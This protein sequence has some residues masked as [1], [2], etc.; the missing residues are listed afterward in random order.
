VPAQRQAPSTLG[1]LLLIGL[2]AVS[3]GTTGSVTTILVARAE[4]SPLLIGAVRMWVAAIC[5]VAGTCLAG[6]RVSLARGDWRRAI[7]LGGCMAAYQV[8]YFTAVT[9]AGI[10]VAAVVAICSAPLLIAGLAAATLREPLSR[11][12]LLALG[13][14]V[15]GTALLIATPRGALDLSERGVA[16]ALLALAAGLAYALYVVITKRALAG[17]APLPLASATFAAAAILLAPVFAWVEAPVR[18]IVLGWP[19]LLYLGAVATAGAY[20]IYTVGLR[21]V[22]ASVAGI[23]TLL[24]PLTATVLGTLVF[25]E[26]LGSLGVLGAALLLT[27]LVLV[28]T[29]RPS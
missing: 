21:R 14:G 1:G 16:G 24:E 18:Q 8:T 22:P 23:A 5:L 26:R 7:A 10:T 11:R 3:W 19:W 15:V 28:L 2:A 9:L 4:A 27:S 6:G 12:V 20:A 17:S 29:D 25:G 13:I